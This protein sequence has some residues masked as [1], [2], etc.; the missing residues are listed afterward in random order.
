M[1]PLHKLG[2]LPPKALLRKA[3]LILESAERGLLE[4]SA[5][6][7]AHSSLDQGY[8]AGV[9]EL[10]SDA[11]RTLSPPSEDTGILRGEEEA[12]ILGEGIAILREGTRDGTVLRRTINE[13]RHIAYGRIGRS[14][15][16]WDL[17][18]DSGFL[19]GKNR[20]PFPGMRVF[21]E[22]IRS[23]YNVGSMFR[24]AEVFGA[25]RLILSPLCASPDHPRAARTSMGC[26]SAV[27]WEWGILGELGEVPLF[28]LETGGTPIQEFQFPP[29]GIMIVGSE[30]LGVSPPSLVRAQA[31]WG[32]LSIPTVGVKGSLNV[33][34]AFGIA[35]STWAAKLGAGL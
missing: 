7:S 22:D 4:S 17:V 14:V 30:E 12:R 23:P 2:T 10:V 15:A 24:T 13:V 18:D 19:N 20:R 26:V 8:L 34:V 35:L 1:I 28:A 5:G 25:E 6:H 21:F 11:L 9:A 31:S 3:A 16:D 32:R 27:P 29:S 33:S